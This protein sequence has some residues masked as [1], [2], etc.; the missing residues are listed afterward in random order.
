MTIFA[1]SLL[2]FVANLV[3]YREAMVLL[4][5]T[6]GLVLGSGVRLLLLRRRQRGRRQTPGHPGQ[7]RFARGKGPDAGTPFATQRGSKATAKRGSAPENKT[8]PLILRPKKPRDSQEQSIAV[9][10]EGKV[11]YASFPSTKEG[12][13]RALEAF[14]KEK[15]DKG[16]TDGRPL[17]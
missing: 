8:I 7:S 9:Q 14:S 3:A 1:I 2:L 6:G 16:D 13:R 17:Q 5:F 10:R 11:L 4:P 12:R 15:P